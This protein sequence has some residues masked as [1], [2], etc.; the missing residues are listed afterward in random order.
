MSKPKT[1][2]QGDLLFVETVEKGKPQRII[3]DG[4]LA[5]GEATGH[6]HRLEVSDKAKVFVDEM[7]QMLIEAEAP[8]KVAHEEHETL[9]LPKG[10]YKVVHQREWSPEEIRPVQD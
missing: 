9:T 8:A 4:V 7:N 1:Y 2:R 6:A 5:Y 10:T 3:K